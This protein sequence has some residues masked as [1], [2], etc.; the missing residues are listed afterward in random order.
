[1]NLEGGPSYVGNNCAAPI[2]VNTTA[3][4][5]LK[6]PIFYAMGHFS[7]FVPTDSHKIFASGFD[8]QVPVTSFK[9]PDGGIVVVIINK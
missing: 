5:I 8:F 2:V 3:Q 4:E 6:T 7:K 9:R 1:M